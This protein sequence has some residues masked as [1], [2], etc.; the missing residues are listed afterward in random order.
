MGSTVKTIVLLV[1][2]VG[3]IGVATYFAVERT[4]PDEEGLGYSTVLMCTNPACA[5]IF[6]GRIIAGQP[7]PFRCR[8]CGKMTA[9]RA[10]KCLDCEKVFALIVREDPSRPESEEIRTEECPECR[11]SDF[12]LVQS[13]DEVKGSGSQE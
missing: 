3:V 9:Y 8:Y 7:P 5:K 6:Q 11:S 13:M 12:Q 10:V 2:L 1:V 4:K